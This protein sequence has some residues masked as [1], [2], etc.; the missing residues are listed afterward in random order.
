VE[1]LK[2]PQTT[3]IFSSLTSTCRRHGIDPQH[4][5]TQPPAPETVWTG[6]KDG[7]VPPAIGGFSPR[8]V[9]IGPGKNPAI[10][11]G[12]GGLGMMTGSVQNMRNGRGDGGSL[13]ACHWEAVRRGKMGSLSSKMFPYCSLSGLVRTSPCRE[14]TWQ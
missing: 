2:N 13:F 4:Y 6:M 9:P 1:R 14:S 8:A 7:G 12:D 10:T 11:A 5:L 3:A